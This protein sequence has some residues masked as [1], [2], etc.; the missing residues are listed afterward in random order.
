MDDTLL[1]VRVDEGSEEQKEMMTELM[2]DAK[3]L[4][5]GGPESE[6]EEK[7]EWMGRKIR[8][9]AGLQLRVD[10]R[11]VICKAHNKNEESI[12][13]HEVQKYPRYT[14]GYSYQGDQMRVGLMQGN[15]RRL[16][17]QDMLDEDFIYDLELDL[18]EN[19]LIGTK[20][21]LVAEALKKL[22]NM[23]SGTGEEWSAAKEF[24]RQG[25]AQKQRERSEISKLREQEKLE[26]Q[27]GA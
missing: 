9:W 10:E 20:W 13:T 23:V 16:R 4:Y 26:H 14:Q 22:P 24:I 3:N 21:T 6:V 18:W 27:G 19:L 2:E 17:T 15:A 25:L 11:G 5:T 8:V 12:L 1:V 7:V